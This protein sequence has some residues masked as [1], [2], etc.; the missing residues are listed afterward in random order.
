M[1]LAAHTVLVRMA[2]SDRSTFLAL[3][4]TLHRRG[5]EVVAAQ[6]ETTRDFN[7]QFTATFLASRERAATVTATLRNLVDVFAADLEE[8]A[9]LAGAAAQ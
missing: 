2:Q 4:S 9:E 5:V 8:P 6:L 3:V 7:V 1:D